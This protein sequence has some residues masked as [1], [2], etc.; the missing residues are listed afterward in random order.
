M[1]ARYFPSKTSTQEIIDNLAYSMN[2]MCDSSEK[3]S[4]E[5][6]GFMAYMNDWKMTNF[7]VMYC[8]QFMMMLQGRIP[9]RVRMFLIVNPPSW[10][11]SDD[12]L[13]GVVASKYSF[14]HV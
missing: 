13:G 12:V 14:L 5:G 6:I 1:P 7:S 4:A 11:V 3:C 2:Y 8:Y 10:F 9:V